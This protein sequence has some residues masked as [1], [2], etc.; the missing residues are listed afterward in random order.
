MENQDKTFCQLIAEAA[1]SH[2]DKTAMKVI[3]EEN[4]KYKFGEMLDAVR[5]IAFRLEKEGVAFGD[6]VA[7]I[8]E[9]HPRWAIAYFGILFRGAVCVPVDPHGEIETIIN[10]FEDSEAKMAFIGADFIENFH[11][12]EESA[13]R[14]IPAVLLQDAK[15]E[16]GFEPFNDW[17][18]TEY[19]ADYAAKLPPAKNEDLA[20]LMYTSGTTGKPKGV[21]LTHGNI[22]YET[23]GCQEVMNISE[24]EVV[25]SVLPLFHVFAQ[26][27]NLWVIASIGGTICYIKELTPA[28]LENAFKTKE[29]TLLTGVP[30]IWY[31]FHKK[32][33]DQVVAQPFPVRWLF[34]KMLKLN[35]FLREKFNINLGKT[36]FKKV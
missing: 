30:R 10:F 1:Q 13:G 36:F 19:P 23:Q 24:T 25:L 18:K 29:I 8:G 12:I 15:S 27:V 11:K 4:A 14:K 28:E 7:L 5:S 33:F 21:P 31:L 9:N 32:I 20:V 6:R 16:N 35:F 22:F 3:G 26:V 2:A 17:A 34:A